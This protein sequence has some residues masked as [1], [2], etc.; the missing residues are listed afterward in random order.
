MSDPIAAFA[1]V[2]RRFCGWCESQQTPD[3]LAL[4]RL[5]AELYLAALHLPEGSADFD[6]AERTTVPEPPLQLT[7][8]HF[9]LYNMFFIPSSL[10]QPPCMGDLTDDF[11]DIYRDLQ[12]GIDLY[13]AIQ[14][15]AAAW[16][17]NF[18][19]RSHWGHH[20]ASALFALEAH[21]A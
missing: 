2:A 8:L 6:I 4:R 21:E 19:F 10:D 11:L 7:G 20:A 13:D 12:S 18:S 3:S 5:L 17:W 15:E 9:H 1:A 16:T 14:P